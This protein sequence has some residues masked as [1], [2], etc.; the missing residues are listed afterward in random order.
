[1]TPLAGLKAL[2]GDDVNITVMR[3]RS[4]VLS[5]IASDY[6]ASRH[7][8]GTPAW[9]ISYYQEEARKSLLNESWIVDSSFTSDKKVLQHITMKGDIKPL[10]S[11]VHKLN[12]AIDG[13]FTLKIDGEKVVDLT[14]VGNK[15]VSSNIN[16]KYHT[17]VDMF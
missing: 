4:T 17:C 8:T 2:L 1:M 16:L 5:P 15:V 6:V 7:W 10:K 12:I 14:S 3:A 11:G 13:S 9:N